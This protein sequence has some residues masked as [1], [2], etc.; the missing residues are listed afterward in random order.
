M[1]LHGAALQWKNKAEA[2]WKASRRAREKAGEAMEG[3]LAAGV[4]GA[5]GFGLGAL[6]GTLKDPKQWQVAGVPIPLWIAA[7]GHGLA[8]AGVGRNTEAYFRAAGNGALAVH[9]FGMGRKIIEARQGT[10][11]QVSGDEHAALP[12]ARRGSGITEADLARMAL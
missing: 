1:A 2:A 7:A 11:P 8:L 12:S 9:A 5:V 6:A 10:T 4:T 3:L